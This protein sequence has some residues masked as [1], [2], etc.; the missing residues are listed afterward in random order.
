MIMGI[1]F[2][3]LGLLGVYGFFSMN[4]LL[5]TLGG[6]AGIVSNLIGIISGQQRSIMTAILA[7]I[8]GII[9][10]SS[11]NLSIWTGVLI[12]MCFESAIMGILGFGSLLVAIIIQGTSR[13]N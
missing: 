2:T 11:V 4:F 5:L 1:I 13:Q 3:F 7:I 10:A 12:G 9:Y 8:I 6:I